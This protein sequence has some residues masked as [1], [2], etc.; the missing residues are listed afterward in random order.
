MDVEEGEV[1]A[2]HGEGLVLGD[3]ST[4]SVVDGMVVEIMG[5]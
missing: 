5:G 3:V 4:R 1:G 2:G